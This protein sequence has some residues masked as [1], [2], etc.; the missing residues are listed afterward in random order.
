MMLENEIIRSEF[1]F[2]IRVMST[3]ERCHYI[4]IIFLNRFQSISTDLS[5]KVCSI[6][7]NQ[8]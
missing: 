1:R 6:N 4:F 2:H 7:F 3:Y 8:F 5:A